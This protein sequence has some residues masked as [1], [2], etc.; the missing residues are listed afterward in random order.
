MYDSRLLNESRW[1]EVLEL[2]QA[3]GWLMLPIALASVLA[4]A[5]C[6]E[7]SWSL[8]TERVVPAGLAAKAMAQGEATGPGAADP[9]ATARFHASHLGVVLRAGLGSAQ[10]G[11]ERMKEA[12][13][14]AAAG[15]VHDLERYLTTLGTIAAISPL[16]GLLGTVVGM[17]RVFDALM[18]QGTGN[19]SSLAG[20]IAEALV[21]TAAGLSV[22]I[23][24]LIFHR[25]LS[26]KVD[27]L[28]V[29]MESEATLLLDAVHPE[30]AR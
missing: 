11:R 9:A 30:Q 22:A 27:D 5:I 8:R 25:H 20:G 12:M 6:I 26:R 16:L 7:R 14:A 18:A 3:G 28:V 10:R 21:T 13:E 19:V 2:L 23:P 29:A 15:V 24:S 1:I 17:I 4:L